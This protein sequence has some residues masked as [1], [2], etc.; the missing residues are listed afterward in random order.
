MEIF[1]TKKFLLYHF[2][3][4]TLNRLVKTTNIK[5]A[6]FCDIVRA[7]MGLSLEMLYLLLLKRVRCKN[8]NGTL[9]ER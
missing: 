3:F 9:S 8:D 6:T 1:H 2:H 4:F 5:S 7:L